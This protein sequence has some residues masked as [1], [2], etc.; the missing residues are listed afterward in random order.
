[1][2]PSSPVS[3]E[4]FL[5]PC[6]FQSPSQALGVHG[7]SVGPLTKSTASQTPTWEVSSLL[8]CTQ[9]G[10][11]ASGLQA[12]CASRWQQSAQWYINVFVLFQILFPFR[13]LQNIEQISLCGTEGPCWLSILN[14]AV[15]IRQFQ[16][17]NLSFSLPCLPGNHKFIL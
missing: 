8:M 14:V 13:L 2:E 16:I 7:A 9:N 3:R 17:P 4:T 15:S 10:A 11:R 1:M 5:G 6:G 12:A